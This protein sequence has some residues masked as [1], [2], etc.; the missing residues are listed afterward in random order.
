MVAEWEAGERD[1]LRG[2]RLSEKLIISQSTA[3]SGNRDKVSEVL[4]EG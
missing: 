1:L 4:Q 2:S 3:N